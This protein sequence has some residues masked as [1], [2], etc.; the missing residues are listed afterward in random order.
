LAITHY[1]VLRRHGHKTLLELT[2]ETGRKHQIRVQLAARGHPLIGDRKYGAK[3]GPARRL[4]L[5]ACALKFR[6]PVTGAVL[7][8]RSGLPRQLKALIGMEGP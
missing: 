4:A 1:R 7:E 8:F 6:H 5:H 2:L 3:D